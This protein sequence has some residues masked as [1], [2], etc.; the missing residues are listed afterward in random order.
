LTTQHTEEAQLEQEKVKEVASVEKQLTGADRELATARAELDRY[1]RT[2]GWVALGVV[3]GLALV[4]GIVLL[5]IGVRRQMRDARAGM[6]Q[7]A[8]GLGVLGVAFVA[9]LIALW[10]VVSRGDREDRVMA[11]NKRHAA[12]DQ[13]A[14]G[15]ERLAG[16]HQRN[17]GLMK[18]HLELPMMPMK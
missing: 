3:G 8:S 13:M 12:V 9:G 14:Q 2:L 6:P 4:L 10:Y 18:G 11:A 17:E 1:L 15:A 7:L 5:T 16:G